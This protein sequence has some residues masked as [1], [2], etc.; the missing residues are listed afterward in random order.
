MLVLVFRVYKIILIFY[1]QLIM[2]EMQI[3]RKY[4]I[5][6]AK[7]C[8]LNLEEA[9][10]NALCYELNYLMKERASFFDNLNLDHLPPLFLPDFIKGQ[11]LR[12]D[13]PQI[14]SSPMGF[15]HNN[16]S[17]LQTHKCDCGKATDNCSEK[18]LVFI[19]KKR[20]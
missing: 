14:D 12:S 5:A 15:G 19:A 10:I 6:L 8:C 20:S 1:A 13:D 11:F 2:D 18:R 9:Q 3:D 16:F 4:V 7:E 17:I